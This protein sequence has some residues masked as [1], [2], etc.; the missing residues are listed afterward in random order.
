MKQFRKLTWAVIAMMSIFTACS[1]VDDEPEDPSKP[2]IENP[3]DNDGNSIVSGDGTEAKPFNSADVK[4]LNPTSKDEPVVSGIWA[5]GY[6]VGYMDQEFNKVFG[7]Q[8]SYNSDFNV[9][10]APT[11]TETDFEK[12]I[13]VKIPATLRPAIG[14]MTTPANMGKKLTIKGDVALYNGIAGVINL[15]DYK[16]DGK[17]AEEVPSIGDGTETKP[18]NISDVKGKKP[19]SKDE[20]VVK[21]VWAEAYIVGYRDQTFNDFFG[22]Q[23][24]Y[25]S[26]FNVFIADSKTENNIENCISVKIPAALRP[27]I[28][29]MSTPANMGKK[30]SIKGDIALYNGIAGMINLTAYK[31][32]GV[33]SEPEP[34]VPTEGAILEAAFDKDL[35]N[36]TTY[37]VVGDLAWAVDVTNKY[38][39]MSG[40]DNTAKK[41]VANEDWL[42]SPA[43]DLSKITAANLK[44]SHT[45]NK[46]DVANL[47]TNHTLWIS[48]NYTEGAP[49]TAVWEQL[50]IPTYPA[51]TT[52]AF[53]ES[54]EIAIPASFLGKANIRIAFKYLCSDKE[55]ASWEIKNLIVK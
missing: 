44:F 12:C 36:F 17:G 55:S 20:P 2:G 11:K 18:F 37:S 41:S 26:D 23:D 54:G 9:F 49:E 34:E 7:K 33:G 24:S 1:N 51:G 47:K 8:E 25:T 45:I 27:A 10:I 14:L 3:D 31:I 38:I 39:K 43:M 42:I 50:T 46:G 13:S 21:E 52:W 22:T 48:S 19:T 16:L 30:L 35:A 40:Y 5:E 15:S 28:G 53:V 4:A 29:L 32:D 6:I